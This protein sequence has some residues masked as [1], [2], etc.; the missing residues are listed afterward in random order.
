MEKSNLTGTFGCC[1]RAATGHA[2]APPSSL[3]NARRLIR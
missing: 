3:M 1:A 2:G